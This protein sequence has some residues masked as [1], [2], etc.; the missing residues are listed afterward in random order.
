MDTLLNFF[1]DI[2][3]ELPQELVQTLLTKPGLRIERIVSRGHS[4]PERFWF[5]QDMHEWVILIRGAARLRFEDGQ[6]VE[7]TAGSF[8][9]I[10]AHRRHRV[11]WTDPDQ[12]S[13]W[14]AVHYQ[15]GDVRECGPYDAG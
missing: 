12:D 15:A 4:S 3:S 9:E 1:A 8:L 14:L 2:S 11:E 10:P 6:V 13:I 5:D 7:M